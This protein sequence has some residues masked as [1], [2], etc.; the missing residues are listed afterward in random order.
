M[1]RLLPAIETINVPMA[2]AE[3]DIKAMA[4]SPCTDELSLIFKTKNDEMMTIGRATQIGVKPRTVDIA[5]AP[6][7]TCES[8]SPSIDLFLSTR[9]VPTNAAEREISIPTIKARTIKV[10]ENISN[11][12]FMMNL[13]NIFFSGAKE[14]GL[15]VK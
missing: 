13:S 3:A 10:Y 9:G 12:L 7:A 8:P 5:N 1:S 6:K 15:I 2:S 4:E 11:K 14:I